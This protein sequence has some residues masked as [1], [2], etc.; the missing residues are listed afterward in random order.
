MDENLLPPDEAF[1]RQLRRTLRELPDAPV[2]WQR[3]AIDLWTAREAPAGL[4][5]VLRRIVA[6]LSFDS[7]AVPAPALGLR[8][9]RAGTRHLLFTAQGRD[10]D[11]RIAP[12]GDRYQLAGQILGP[13]AE[14]RVEVESEPGAGDAVRLALL[15]ELGEFRVD[16]LV[17]G[18]YRLTLHV[19][20]MAIEL[21]SIEVGEGAA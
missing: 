4:A 14:G 7:W 19:G 9:A 17:R 10:V 20:D 21:P 1:E 6:Q 18:Q 8:G 12:A 2:A 13:D 15:D 11:L 5:S 3:Q 16:G